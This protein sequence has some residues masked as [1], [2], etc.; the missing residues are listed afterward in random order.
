MRRK[1]REVKDINIIEKILIQCKTASLAMISDGEPYVVPLSY[2]YE[3]DKDKLI[4]YFHCAKE[5]KKLDALKVN[6][7]VAFNV[8]N[9]GTPIYADTPCNS[10][11]Y[12]SSVSGKGNA[13][14]VE[15]TMEKCHGLE[16]IFCHQ[17]GRWI[18]FNEEQAQSVCVFKVIS[19]EFTGKKKDRPPSRSEI[20]IC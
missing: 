6:N 11:Y 14:L 13:F 1:D 10:G 17:A 3:W 4:L 16:L 9:E 19:T 20:R 15:D 8:C 5:G 18:Q 2:G 12:Y 7:R